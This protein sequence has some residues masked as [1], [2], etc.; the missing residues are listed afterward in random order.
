MAAIPPAA[1]RLAAVRHP[2]GTC[3]RFVVKGCVPGFSYVAQRS[4][5]AN[6][7]TMGGFGSLWKAVC[8]RGTGPRGLAHTIPI[9][10]HWQAS[11]HAARSRECPEYAEYAMVVAALAMMHVGMQQARHQR[12]QL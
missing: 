5:S 7:A 1:P 4:A 6:R 11:W 9:A 10:A 3:P 12:R 2:M 8:H